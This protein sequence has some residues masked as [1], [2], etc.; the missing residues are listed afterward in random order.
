LCFAPI[1][2]WSC[3]STAVIWLLSFFKSAVYVD[4][5]VALLVGY[6][7]VSFSY[8]VILSTSDSLLSNST[9][10]LAN[11]CSYVW[12]VGSVVDLVFRCV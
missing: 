9:A 7:E 12:V 8:A 3:F 10:V 2:A 6:V 11:V 5:G 4:G 1:A